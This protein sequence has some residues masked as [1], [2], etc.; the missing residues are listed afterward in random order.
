M[1]YR[2]Y[3]GNLPEGALVSLG[4]NVAVASP[5]LTFLQY[6]SYAEDFIQVALFGYE[7]C[8]TYRF[9]EGARTFSYGFPPISTQE[10][11]VRFLDS[12]RN[13]HGLPNARKA[14]EY[15][16]DNSESYMETALT[17]LWCLP[18]KYGGRALSFPKLNYEV[19]RSGGRPDSHG[20]ASYRCDLCWPERKVCVE[21][22]SDEHHGSVEQMA[23]D[24]EKRIALSEMGYT[25]LEMTRQ[26]VM[27]GEAFEEF[28][29]ALMNA[30]N[31]H[32]R[33]RVSNLDEKRERLRKRLLKS[34]STYV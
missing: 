27:D 32:P 10:Q 11:L 9:A 17:L 13:L 21:Y 2:G 23:E 29:A 5:E 34:F 16:R 31:E 24:S 33:I 1:D 19:K 25:V 7:L 14:A 28:T 8:G 15:V 6:A 18:G 26:Q 4:P 20:R 22:D 3:Y 30:L 12:C